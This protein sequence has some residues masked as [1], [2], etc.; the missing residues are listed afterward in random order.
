MADEKITV[1]KDELAA[2]VKAAVSEDKMDPAEKKARSLIRDEVKSVLGEFFT[3]D[4]KDEKE[5]SGSAIG[6][7]FGSGE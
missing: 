4:E 1:T 5:S 2:M 7:F 6:S 3:F